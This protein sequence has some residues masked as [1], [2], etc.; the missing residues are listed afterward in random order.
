M[1]VALFLVITVCLIV[2]ML[3]ITTFIAAFVAGF[4]GEIPTPPKRNIKIYKPAKYFVKDSRYD[5]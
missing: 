5:W 4:T 1:F 2:P 3:L